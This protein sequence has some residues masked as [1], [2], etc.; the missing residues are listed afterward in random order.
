[1]ELSGCGSYEQDSLVIELMYG[2]ELAKE[3]KAHVGTEGAV[4][5][6][7]MLAEKIRS[8]FEKALLILKW[9]GSMEQSNQIVVPT[10]TIP[11]S[12]ISVVGSPKSEDL[13]QQEA[14][15]FSRKRKKLPSWTDQVKV[16]SEN[17]VEGPPNDG[18]SWRKYGQKDILGAKHPRSYY[19]CTY[20]TYQG[21]SAIKQVQ[22]N[23]ED[24]SL[25]DITYKGTHTCAPRSKSAPT[26]PEKQQCNK[27]H[28]LPIT[29]YQQ[30][31]NMLLNFQTGLS[32]DT[33]NLENQEMELPFPTSGPVYENHTFTPTTNDNFCS[34]FQ[35]T[36]TLSP[37]T[38]TSNYF[39]TSPCNM[40]AF[41]G[42]QHSGSDFT[43]IFSA[44]TSGANSPIMGLDFPFEQMEFNPNFSY[45]SHAFP[46]LPSSS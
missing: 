25:F 1:M 26:S 32:I 42:V 11:A 8:S 39:S 34:G 30:Q 18:H 46:Y 31:S 13:N 16:N 23:D 3:L 7:G 33:Q 17:G 29:V 6:T 9:S 45:D 4:E 22:R 15:D 14:K 40:S 5:G 38:S 36:F 10:S 37:A 41:G 27:H 12:P 28:Q 24:P 21:C 44:T 19:R 35:Q 43:E 2:M 20:R